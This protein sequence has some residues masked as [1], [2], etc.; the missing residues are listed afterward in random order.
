MAI[1]LGNIKLPRG[2]TKKP[3]R[4]GRGEGSGLGKTSGRGNKGQLSRSGGG[5]RV[6]FEGGQ[7]PLIRRIPKRGFFNKFRKE[8]SVVNLRD[9]SVFEANE[10]VDAEKL[11][12]KGLINSKSLPV[13]VLG[14]GE[15]KV[16][17]TVKANKFSQTAIEKITK[18][19]G[20]AEEI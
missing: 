11:Y 6:G 19:G 2:A 18:A 4:R 1:S 15:L 5:T 17:L 8:F 12:S 14:D 9:L 16:A 7:M 10:V 13:K 3:K 20:K